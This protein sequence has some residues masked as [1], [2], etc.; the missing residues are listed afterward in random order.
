MNAVSAT[1][2]FTP[3][4]SSA[5][6]NGTVVQ[7]VDAAQL[8]WSQAVLSKDA[9]ALLSMYSFPVLFKPT[10]AAKVRTTPEGALSYFIGGDPD[11]PEDTGFLFNN[12]QKLRWERKA[13]QLPP[14]PNG[15]ILDMGHY[16]FTAPDGSE[17][18]VDYTFGYVP[19]PEG[20]KIDLHHSSL[21]V[22]SQDKPFPLWLCVASLAGAFYLG[23]RS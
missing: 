9:D 20:L 12:W 7:A 23:R 3:T 16:W 4:A 2:G 18:K 8:M 22:D 17:T 14:G 19:T 1:N 11:F 15:R 13:L 6:Q 10:L 21:S 5:A